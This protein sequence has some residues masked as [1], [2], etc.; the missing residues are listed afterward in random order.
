MCFS[1][2]HLGFTVST[3][4]TRSFTAFFVSIINCPLAT[5]TPLFIKHL[6]RQTGNIFPKRRD[7]FNRKQPDRQRRQKSRPLFTIRATHKQICQNAK[8]K[9]ESVPAPLLLHF[10]FCVSCSQFNCSMIQ[11]LPDLLGRDNGSR[12]NKR[13]IESCCFFCV[14]RDSSGC[15][16]VYIQD[17]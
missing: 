14:Q 5:K 4:L 6:K 9:R 11:L 13:L 8:T 2:S 16:C 15:M 1:C 7:K 17:G 12:S 3:L 10:L